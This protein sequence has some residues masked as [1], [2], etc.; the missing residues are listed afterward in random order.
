MFI[1]EKFLVITCHN[2]HNVMCDEYASPLTTVC[3]VI[4]QSQVYGGGGGGGVDHGEKGV[5]K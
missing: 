2:S 4:T 1:W 5:E 3:G